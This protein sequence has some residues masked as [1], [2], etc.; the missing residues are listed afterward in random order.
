MNLDMTDSMGPGKL[1]RHVQKSVVQ[2]SVISKFSCSI[3]RCYWTLGLTCWH[4]FFCGPLFS[5]HLLVTSVVPMG[6]D[7][8]IISGW[9]IAF[10]LVY[11][12]FASEICTSTFCWS[13]AHSVSF[14]QKGVGSRWWAAGVILMTKDYSEQSRSFQKY[15]QKDTL[16]FSD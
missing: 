2:W 13:M 12:S 8:A 4:I 5:M 6:R 15:I 11:H 16:L 3:G 9:S 7:C 10:C 1:V 14:Y